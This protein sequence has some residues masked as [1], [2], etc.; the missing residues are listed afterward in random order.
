MKMVIVLFRFVLRLKDFTF[1]PLSKVETELFFSM[2][3]S[4]H[5][6]TSVNIDCDIE[7]SR[8]ADDQQ[9]YI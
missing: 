7:Y 1:S 2:V 9:N 4:L 3:K 5:L 6:S 8:V